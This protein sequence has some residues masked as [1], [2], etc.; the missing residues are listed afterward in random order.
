MEVSVVMFT[1]NFNLKEQYRV[2]LTKPSEL[3]HFQRQ[4]F[5]FSVSSGVLSLTL[6]L[7]HPS[8]YIKQRLEEEKNQL[9]VQCVE[10]GYI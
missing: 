7:S 10:F 4:S 9:K 1:K 2:F 3:S 8:K 5:Y 6:I